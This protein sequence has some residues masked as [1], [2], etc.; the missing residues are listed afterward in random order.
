MRIAH[1]VSNF[2][3][4]GDSDVYGKS[5]AAYN[6][7]ISL[8]ERGH[9]IHVF[10]VSKVNESCFEDHGNLKIQRYKPIIN[11]KSEGFSYKI[12]GDSLN[13]DF[14][15]VHV[16]SGISAAFLAGYRFSVKKNVPLVITW[17]GDSVRG[18][19]RYQGI[20]AGVATIFYKHLLAKRVLNRAKAIISPSEYY[21]EESQFLGEYRNKVFPIPNGINVEE[22]K[23]PYSKDECKEKLGLEGKKVILFVGSLYHLKGPHVLLKSAPPILKQYKDSVFV[24]VGGGDIEKYQKLSKEL[25]IINEVIFPG[26][27]QGELKTVYYNAA[28]IFVLPSFVE[29]FPLVLLEASASSLPM[30]VS[31]LDT[32]KC[33]VREGYNGIFAISGDVESFKDAVLMLLKNDDLRVEMGFNAFHNVKN[34]SWTKIA[35]DTENLYKKI[36]IS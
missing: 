17:H 18:H 7:C 20:V 30:V 29:V 3:K 24:F 15:L 36:I 35:E 28:D 26:Y 13:Y 10:T 12:I 21:I 22:F 4:K 31:N 14:D 6:I 8:A 1:F 34:F 23:L 2:P 27:V 5:L 25:K 32:F 16:H 11:Y 19:G 9:E 33:I